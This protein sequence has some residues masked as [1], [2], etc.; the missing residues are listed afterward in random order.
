MT[1][2]KPASVA[3]Q[4]KLATLEASFSV[5]YRMSRTRR[6]N[7]AGLLLVKQCEGAKA[8]R[9]TAD[10]GRFH[11]W[12]G[13]GSGSDVQAMVFCKARLVETGISPEL[14]S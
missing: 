4:L 11:G 2:D 6:T 3:R 13:R 9:G 5:N 1:H 7:A 14:T 12:I 8:Q 10:A